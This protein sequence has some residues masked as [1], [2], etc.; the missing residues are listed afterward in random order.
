MFNW[1]Y[2]TIGKLEIYEEESAN[3]LKQ[4]ILT[5]TAELVSVNS[6]R[7]HKL[8]TKYVPLE[9]KNIILSLVKYPKLG[10]EYIDHIIRLNSKISKDSN[11]QLSGDIATIYAELLIQENKLKKV[12]L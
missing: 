9:E 6:Y 5:R 1:L 4:K 11:F 3:A 10:I 12:F 7:A 2:N 8:F